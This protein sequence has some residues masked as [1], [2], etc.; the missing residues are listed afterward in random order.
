MSAVDCLAAAAG[1][2]ESPEGDAREQ[3]HYG[4]KQE[5]SETSMRLRAQTRD[6]EADSPDLEEG[7]ASQADPGVVSPRPEAPLLLDALTRQGTVRCV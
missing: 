5:P 1:G 4:I 2:I 3:Q 7:E 6:D